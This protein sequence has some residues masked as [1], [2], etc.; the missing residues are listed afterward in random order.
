MSISFNLSKKLILLV[1]IV[2]VVA[3]SITGFLSFNYADQILKERAGDQLFGESTVR[4]ETLRLLFESRIE[5]NNIL[6]NNPMIQLLISEMN[7]V[8]ENE[9]KENKEVNRRDFL[10]Q[11][12]A[13]Q[14]LIGFSIGFEDVKI[15]GSNGSVYF[16]L[17]GIT[18]E[19]FLE[20]P[21]FQKGL[22]KPF[23]EFEP[24]E[25]GKKMIVVSPVFADDSK[26]GDESI[27]VIISRMRTAAI[28]NV[29][30]N[31]SGL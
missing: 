25:A 30:L 8:P 7:K 2:S 3:L 9:L 22:T 4:G 24:T 20:N 15:I 26:I 13:F 11:V 10:I 12:Q 18:D 6:A 23:I 27:G 17:G 5:Q 29:L 14:E 28:D 1:M 19:G 16:S 21:L 31:Q